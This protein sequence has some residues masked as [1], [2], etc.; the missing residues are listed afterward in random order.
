MGELLWTIFSH[1]SAIA[2]PGEIP[3]LLIAGLLIA[4]ITWV[5]MAVI[6]QHIMRFSRPAALLVG[7]LFVPALI[8]AVAVV[9]VTTAPKGPPPND[10]PAMLFISLV[11]LSVCSLPFSLVATAIYVRQHRRKDVR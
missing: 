5:F 6:G 10:G 9:L 4:L 7:A 1:P 8:V 3:F 2:A 11:V